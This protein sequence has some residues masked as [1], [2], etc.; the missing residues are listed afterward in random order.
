MSDLTSRNKALMRRVYEE[1]WNQ[2][3][4]SQAV[5]IF[6]RPQGVERFVSQFLS[7]FPDLQHTIEEM[8]AEDDRVA[9]RFSAR[10][11]HTGQWLHFAPTGLSIQYTGVTLARFARDKIIAHETWWDKAGLMEQIMG[12]K[13]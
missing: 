10:G 1:L 12:G 13:Q 9:V 5:E 6:D 4:A 11:T 3:R 8:I 2:A 7:S